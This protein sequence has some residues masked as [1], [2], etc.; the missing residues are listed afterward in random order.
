MI[1]YESFII[2]LYELTHGKFQSLASTLRQA[3][4]PHGQRRCFLLKDTP[5]SRWLQTSN[6]VGV[7]IVM[8]GSPK[9]KENDGSFYGKDP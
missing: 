4:P 6:V 9:P 1:N 2:L 7:S 8:G 3:A 5:W